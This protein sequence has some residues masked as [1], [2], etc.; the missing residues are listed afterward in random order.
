MPYGAA[1]GLVPL[2]I[3]C[4][5]EHGRLLLYAGTHHVDDSERFRARGAMLNSVKMEMAIIVI[6]IG[7]VQVGVPGHPLQ[8]V[9]P[10]PLLQLPQSRR[11]PEPRDAPA[12]VPPRPGRG[13]GGPGHGSGPRGVLPAV[14]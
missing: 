3:G 10:P 12:G 6:I 4:L 7:V 14:H 2:P 9:P 11:G 1:P 8:P 5:A 13:G